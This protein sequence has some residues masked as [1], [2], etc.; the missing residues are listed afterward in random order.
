M[1]IKFKKK[2][3]FINLL[4]GVI[5]L[6]T[7]SLGFLLND[8]SS[9]WTDYVFIA[10]G[11]FY[12]AHYVY[13]IKHQYL[14]LENGSISKNRLYGSEEPIKLNEIIRIKKLSGQYKLETNHKVLAINTNLIQKD[15]LDKLNDTLSKLDLPPDRTPF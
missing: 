8:D 2:R 5:F 15:S 11:I 1:K 13:D 10:I 7:G 4:L 6:S 9:G 12:I 3:V 14:N